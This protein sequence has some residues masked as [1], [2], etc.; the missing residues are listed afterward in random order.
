MVNFKS[1][2][3]KTVYSTSLIKGHD[4]SHFN[5]CRLYLLYDLLLQRF[6]KRK[7][8]IQLPK[9]HLGTSACSTADHSIMI[10]ELTGLDRY[11]EPSFRAYTAIYKAADEQY[12]SPLMTGFNLPFVFGIFTGVEWDAQD[13]HQSYSHCICSHFVEPLRFN[14][15]QMTNTLSLGIT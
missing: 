1:R 15:I 12:W 10:N 11:L 5:N 14:L 13:P 4:P 2:N 6:L 3:L 8:S 9:Y 7:V